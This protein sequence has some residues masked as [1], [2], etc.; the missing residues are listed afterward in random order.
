MTS[1]EK[2][3]HGSA[4]DAGKQPISASAIAW[5]L[6]PLQYCIVWSSRAGGDSDTR[7]QRDP[8]TSPVNEMHGVVL[9]SMLGVGHKQ[10]SNLVLSPTT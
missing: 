8:L 4:G 3:K 9:S 10:G 1:N 5:L 2:A 7:L 6:H